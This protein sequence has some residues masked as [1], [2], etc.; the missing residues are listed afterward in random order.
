MTCFSWPSNPTIGQEVT[1]GNV[2]YKWTG[3]VWDSVTAPLKLSQIT[4][5]GGLD[6]VYRRDTTLADLSAGDF[7]VNSKLSLVDRNYAAFNV[8]AGGT[9]NG[10]NI[11]DAGN[12]NTAVLILGPENKMH[13]KWIGAKEGGFD[14]KDVWEFAASYIRANPS[15]EFVFDGGSYTYSLSPNWAATGVKY[16]T[17]G[18]VKFYYTGTGDSL[19]FDAGPLAEDLVYNMSFCWG[20][21]LHTYALANSGHG[22]YVRSVHHSKIAANVHGCGSISAGLYVAFA[23]VSEFDVVVSVNEGGWYGGA[24]PSIGHYLTSRLPGETASYCIFNNPIVEGTDIGVY[25]H[26]TLGNVYVGGT[27]EGCPS[28]GVFGAVNSRHD[29]FVGTDFEVNGVADVYLLGMGVTFVECD[30]YT[31]ATAGTSSVDTKFLG[32]RYKAL[33]CDTGSRDTVIRDIVYDRFLE[34]AQIV[35][36]G[37][38][39]TIDNVKNSTGVRYLSGA[40]AFNIGTVAVNDAS[41]VS[42]IVPSAKLGDMVNMSLDVDVSNFSVTATVSAANTVKVS[43]LNNITGLPQTPATGTLKVSCT[44]GV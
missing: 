4:E 10:Y 8:V 9:A 44:R 21:R 40:I 7:P 16:T 12:G 23:V 6:G 36:A 30:S 25:L 24:R 41:V 14:N 1:V 33:L 18:D 28:Y 31:A 26:D 15:V 13:S 2:T 17:S 5:D 20:Q 43:F 32:G 35:D 29:R 27:S 42:V 3:V 37:T 22:V 34:G 19:I 39:T 38:R 11:L